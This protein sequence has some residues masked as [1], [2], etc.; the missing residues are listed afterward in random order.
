M[1][2]DAGLSIQLYINETPIESELWCS[3]GWEVQVIFKWR[4]NMAWPKEYFGVKCADAIGDGQGHL[5]TT[6]LHMC[7]CRRMKCPRK[8]RQEG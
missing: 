5:W 2:D 1:H 4:N 7:T 3:E 8:D 6:K